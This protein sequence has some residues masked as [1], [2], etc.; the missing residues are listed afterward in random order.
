MDQRTEIIQ[1]YE[2]YLERRAPGRRTAKD[3]VSDI[4]QFSRFCCKPWREITMHDI[5]AFVD[6]QRQNGLSAAT[7]KR[8]VAALKVF[9]DFMAVFTY[10]LPF[11]FSS[12]LRSVCTLSQQ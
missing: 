9:F 6:N 8:R 2:Q 11:L 7:V 3:Y 1:K 12:G 5:D 4:R 10:F